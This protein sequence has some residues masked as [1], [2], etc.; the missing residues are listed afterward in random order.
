MK[1][2]QWLVALSTVLGAQWAAAQ[3]KPLQ[4][5][6][7]V[8]SRQ[9]GIETNYRYPPERGQRAI[10]ALD[11]LRCDAPLSEVLNG[12]SGCS[13]SLEG[14]CGYQNQEMDVCGDGKGWWADIGISRWGQW[15]G[16]TPSTGEPWPPNPD[17]DVHKRFLWAY[18]YDRYRDFAWEEPDAV[19]QFLTSVEGTLDV[20]NAHTCYTMAYLVGFFNGVW[21]TKREAERSL[22]VLKKQDFI[23]ST[24][25]GAPVR[26]E[27]FYN[28][29]CKRSAD[30]VC[31]QDLAEVFHQ[32][33]AELDGL[34]A[35]R[36]EYFW[37]QVSGQHDQ[38]GS[39]T[40]RLIGR[41]VRSDNALG[42]WFDGLANALLAKI[43]ALSTVLAENPPTA[44]DTA[45]HTA[46]LIR[47][48]QR[49]E[50]AVLVAHSQGNLFVNA[51]Y[52]AY[53]AHSRQTGAEVG[54]DTRYVA[55]QVV[56]IAPASPTLRGPYV[57]ADT[58]IVINGLRRIDGTYMAAP[59]MSLPVSG[60]DRSGH[61]LL[62]TYLDET[63]P[64]RAQVLQLVSQAL[65]AL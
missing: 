48:G 21:N 16:P 58:D 25:R 42:S 38:A 35:R 62:D 14:A 43:T 5:C 17:V 18:R 13:W 40:Q 50:R 52:D 56:H 19:Y 26:Y 12:A 61:K 6:D 22:E 2:D 60:K 57:L 64:A 49:A 3:S 65:D 20:P 34:V 39:F 7:P 29:S 51:A 36:W 32:R 8:A 1:A 23:G 27:L 41:V 11:R 15:V 47:A 33:S 10:D 55:A 28:Q 63:R 53:L 45:G 4:L 46:Q 9:Q 30:D 24:W 54:E 31:L 44:Q 37:E 59:N